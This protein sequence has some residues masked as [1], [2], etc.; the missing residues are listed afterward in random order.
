[1]YIVQ[2]ISISF[3][4]SQELDNSSQNRLIQIMCHG[5]ISQLVE[6]GQECLYVLSTRSSFLIG[7]GKCKQLSNWSEL[8]LSTADRVIPIS[9]LCKFY[10]GAHDA[11]M[12]PYKV[13]SGRQFPVP[14]SFFTLTYT[15]LML[16]YLGL[17]HNFWTWDTSLTHYGT[18]L[19]SF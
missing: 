16:G 8:E 15:S 6:I 13:W 19:L 17:H 3:F 11:I 18:M 9:A 4:Q 14:E 1:M 10:R 7:N 2:G 12:I 5:K